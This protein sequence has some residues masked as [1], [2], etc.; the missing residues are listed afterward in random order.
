MGFRPAAESRL[1]QRYDSLKKN[2]K[3]KDNAAR[4]GKI[5]S[6]DVYKFFEKRNDSTN[7]IVA[8][9]ACFVSVN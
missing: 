6:I 9:V 7:K 4:I 5:Q 3:L 8:V 2:P 1:A